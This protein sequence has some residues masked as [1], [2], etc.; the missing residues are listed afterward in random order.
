MGGMYALLSGCGSEGIAASVAYYGLL[1][2]GH[3]LLQ[4]EGG[5]DPAL[6]PREPISA[7]REL[8]CPLLAFFG[9][10]DTFIT[11]QDVLDL[12][13]ALCQN[14]NFSE[15]V[16]YSGAGHAFLNDTRPD[17]YRPEA[18]TDAWRRMLDFLEVH[19]ASDD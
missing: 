8:S 3:G 5:L 16:R 11:A 4:Q 7:A 2:F 13:A 10:E 19:L 6:K 17:A 12:E 14:E 9:E 15:V 1:S 18:A